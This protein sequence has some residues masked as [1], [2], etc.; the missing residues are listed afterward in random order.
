[1]TK[2]TK[3]DTWEVF[4]CIGRFAA[5]MEGPARY[6]FCGKKFRVESEAWDFAV[7]NVYDMNTDTLHGEMR[8]VLISHNGELPSIEAV[9]P[10]NEDIPHTVLR[11][12]YWLHYSAILPP[13]Y[14]TADGVRPLP[15]RSTLARLRKAAKDGG[16]Y[17][18]EPPQKND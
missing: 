14:L 18:P 2:K 4:F 3:P 10:K 5:S 12:V 17:D 7:Q 11:R 6:I 15:W 16:W 8:F 13:E 9:I 1:M